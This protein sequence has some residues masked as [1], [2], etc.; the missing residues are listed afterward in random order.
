[1][2][3]EFTKVA[4][5]Q[6]V[7][8]GEMKLVEVAGQRVVVANVGGAFYAFGDACTHADGPL[9]E[10]MLE[11][12]RVECPWHGSV[13]DVKSGRPLRGPARDPVP[14]YAVKVEGGS[15]LLGVPKA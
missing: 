6:E 11:D 10:G 1:M 7:P 13:F 4:E 8:A 5:A 9:S 2:A 12:D 14:T 15:I 3:A